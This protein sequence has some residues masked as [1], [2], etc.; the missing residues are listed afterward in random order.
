MR[1]FLLLAATSLASAMPASA[2]EITF[3]V[4]RSVAVQKTIVAEENGKKFTKT[5]NEWV[6]VQ[7]KRKIAP[8]QCAIV[9]CDMWDNH[10]CESAAQRC[11]VLAKKTGPIIDA[12]R[13][14]GFT[15]VHCPSD[16]MGFYKDHAARKRTLDLK[17]HELPKAK[18][19][20]A[21]PLP[22]DDSDG[23]CDDAKPVKQ[24]RAWKRQ[25]EAITIDAK[26]DFITDHGA[27]LWNLMQE[28]KITTV[29]V[30]GVHTNMCILNRTFSIKQ[31]R[32]WD[33]NCYLVRDLTDAMYNPKMKPMVTHD[34]GTQLV[35]AHIQQYWCPTVT[36]KMFVK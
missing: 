28:K 35:I 22:I 30:L 15:I 31:L 1:F 26:H 19:F 8:E 32:K 20:P 6:P 33:V 29:F 17:K 27:D 14:Q 16:T 7:E 2:E 3:D 25:H 24:F 4:A 18:E 10:W 13:K 36:S 12:A 11:D 5:I 9:I 23:G 34:E 21:I